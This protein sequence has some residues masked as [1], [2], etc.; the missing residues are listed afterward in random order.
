MPINCNLLRRVHNSN[1]GGLTRKNHLGI[2]AW[3][4]RKSGKGA[5]SYACDNE[6]DL[7]FGASI[8]PSLKGIGSIPDSD[9]YMQSKCT[10]STI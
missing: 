6:Y 2:N 7:H 9:Q 1:Q 3:T 10:I 8:E 5:D 4:L